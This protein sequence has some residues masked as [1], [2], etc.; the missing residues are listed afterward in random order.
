M[1][2]STHSREFR[3]YEITSTG[4]ELGES[5]VDYQGIITG[6]PMRHLPW[7]PVRSG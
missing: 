2:G 1:R 5:L 6:M 4:V 7:V 3:S